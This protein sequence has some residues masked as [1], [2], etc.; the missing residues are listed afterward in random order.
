MIDIKL[1]GFR[2]SERFKKS[3][4]PCVASRLMKCL[5]QDIFAMH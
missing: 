4:N 5:V 1:F 2:S 3:G